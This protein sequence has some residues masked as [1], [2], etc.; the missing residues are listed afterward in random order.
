MVSNEVTTAASLSRIEATLNGFVTRF[1]RHEAADNA[2]ANKTDAR[3]DKMEVRTEERATEVAKL[4]ERRA[5]TLEAK[6]SDQYRMLKDD[7]N[8]IKD[9][10]SSLRSSV[11]SLGS[12]QT[13]FEGGWKTFT[14]IGSIILSLIVS[15]LSYFKGHS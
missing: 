2:V 11:Q 12:K 6:A 10:I 9:D 5:D 8:T 15:A 3:F 4:V 7:I 1:E 13:F 14:V